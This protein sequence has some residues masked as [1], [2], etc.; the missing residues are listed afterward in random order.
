VVNEDSASI[1][2]IDGATGATKEVAVG[3]IPF[4]VAVNPAA[5]RRTSSPIL[6]DDGAIDGATGFLTKTVTLSDA[7]L[8]DRGQPEDQSDLHCQSEGRECAGARRQD[9]RYHRDGESGA[10][11]Y[12]MTVDAAGQP[13][14]RG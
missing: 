9:Q 4:A 10:L 13:G 7:S 3:E 1:S 5:N 11:P 6:E 8:G 14:I 12:A 2:I